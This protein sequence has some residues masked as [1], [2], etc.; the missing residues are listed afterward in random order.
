MSAPN[1]FF[2]DAARVA[3]GAMGTLAGVKREVEGIVRHQLDR[4][5]AGM[6]LVTREEFD[7]VKEMAAEAR[8]ENE[9]LEARL[10]ALEAKRSRPAARK[11]GASAKKG[12]KKA[13]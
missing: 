4:L 5:L 1:R 13:D 12:T 9:K 10:A 6:D 2:E 11:A 8:R 7:A 3:G